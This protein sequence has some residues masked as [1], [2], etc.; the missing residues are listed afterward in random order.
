MNSTRSKNLNAVD[1]V[2][3]IMA[4]CVIGIH[5]YIFDQK[6]F[7]ITIDYIVNLAVPFFIITTGWLYARKY[8][9]EIDQFGKLSVQYFRLYFVWVLIYLPLILFEYY[10]DGGLTVDN[11]TKFLRKLLLTGS[12]PFS[13]HLW[14][15]LAIATTCLL[16]TFFF[17]F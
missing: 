17:F 11:A 4:F 1:V 9:L 2:K 3:L 7:P 10:H 13:Y 12:N 15:L 5:S 8:G 16:M 14:Y 6:D